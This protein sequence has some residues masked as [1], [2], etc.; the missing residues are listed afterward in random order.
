MY[1][2]NHCLT[3]M[4]GL[5]INQDIVYCLSECV[6]LIIRPAK[7]A[8]T[9]VQDTTTVSL[10][11][12]PSQPPPATT[13]ASREVKRVKRVKPVKSGVQTR[14]SARLLTGKK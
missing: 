4:H 10:I 1:Q 3:E 2:Q 9:P 12:P 5:T 14:R 11:T 8:S 6:T 13:T 7:E